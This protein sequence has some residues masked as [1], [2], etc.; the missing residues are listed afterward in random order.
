MMSSCLVMPHRG[1]LDTLFH[2]FTY[3]KKNHNAEMV[4]EPTEPAVDMKDFSREDWSYSIYADAKEELLSHE[5]IYQLRV[6]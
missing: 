6:W 5:T 4:F 1:H 3:L 2:A